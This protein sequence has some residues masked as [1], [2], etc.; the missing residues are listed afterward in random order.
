MTD[1]EI[2]LNYLNRYFTPSTKPNTNDVLGELIGV[3]FMNEGEFIS[4]INLSKEVSEIY[5]IK[6]TDTNKKVS[7]IVL[8]WLKTK[9]DNV[10][11]DIV[12]S[13]NEVKI[14]FGIRNWE[15]KKD[16]SDFDI[17]WLI[18]KHKKTYDKD[19]VVAVYKEWKHTK[20]IEISD[21]IL[22]S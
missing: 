13:L 6:I 8:D 3:K 19:T 22:N 10:F 17:N 12:D 14:I 9:A 4:S 5:G 1:E 20:I 21:E 18:E 2:I 11:N 15:V 7:E 16:N